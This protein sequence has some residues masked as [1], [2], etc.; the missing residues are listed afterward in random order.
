MVKSHVIIVLL[1]AY[2]V[3]K[4]ASLSKPTAARHEELQVFD[5]KSQIYFLKELLLQ[6]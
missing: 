6:A 3:P 5:A 1:P 4:L 2:T